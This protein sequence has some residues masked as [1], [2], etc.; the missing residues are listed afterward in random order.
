LAPAGNYPNPDKVL[1][2]LKRVFLDYP[3]P[4]NI[5]W[6]LIITI[7]YPSLLK[8]LFQFS[9]FILQRWRVSYWYLKRDSDDNDFDLFVDEIFYDMG[10]PNQ[11][12]A[13]KAKKLSYKFKKYIWPDAFINSI[14]EKS[15]DIKIDNVIKVLNKLVKNYY[16][17][18]LGWFKSFL[19]ERGHIIKVT[20]EQ[21]RNILDRLQYIGNK[22]I[23]GFLDFLI[24]NT[25]STVAKLCIALI[26]NE[27]SDT[28]RG[29]QI[30]RK[31][32]SIKNE[33]IYERIYH[34]ISTNENIIGDRIILNKLRDRDFAFNLENGQLQDLIDKY[35]NSEAN[36]AAK[37]N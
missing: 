20:D 3:T 28:E 21:L 16:I 30:I 11:R 29:K 4:W 23:L 37:K 14:N 22:E 8:L 9:G 18:K 19:A 26:N 24:S 1:E 31:M 10:N 33:A 32:V 7:S 13:R 25:S 15:N 36:A 35:K 12:K 27:W 5:L 2:D 6:P 17:A 34:I